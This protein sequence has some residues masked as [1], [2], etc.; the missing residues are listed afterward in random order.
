MY[1]KNNNLLGLFNQDELQQQFQ[2]QLLQ[3]QLQLQK[4]E[5]EAQLQQQQISE[6]EK[7]IHEIYELI[8]EGNARINEPVEKAALILGKTGAGK[9]TLT[10]LLAKKQLT[11]KLDDATGN[12]LV[13]AI[14]QLD[15]ITISHKSASETKIP[16]RHK[17]ENISLWDCPGFNDTGGVA[18]EIANAF[19]IKKLFETT[20]QLKFIL[21]ISD[22]SM[23]NRSVDVV[24]IVEHFV[25]LFKDVTVL[26]KSVSLV[27]TQALP[28][29]KTEH[30]K[31]AIENIISENKAIEPDTKAVLGFLLNSVHIFYQPVKEGLINQENSIL[32]AINDSTEYIN[33]S[34]NL[35]NIAISK[36]SSEFAEELFEITKSNFT[37]L[38]NTIADAVKNQANKFLNASS[39]SNRNFF[40]ESLEKIKYY[41]GIG[42]SFSN[43][44]FLKTNKQKYF[45]DLDQICSFQECFDKLLSSI[46][47]NQDSDFDT[48]KNNIVNILKIFKRYN[49]QEE[50]NKYSSA[51]IQQTEYVKFLKSVCEKKIIDLSSFYQTFYSCKLL[52]DQ[53]SARGVQSMSLDKNNNDVAYYKKAIQYL[54]KYN[55]SECNKIKAEA[56][57][58]IGKLYDLDGNFKEAI[59]NYL[60]AAGLDKSQLV[61]YKRVGDILLDKKLYQEAIKCFKVVSDY[62]KVLNCFK[63]LIKLNEDDPNL[64]LQ[65]GDYLVSIGRDEKAIG[66][67]QDAFSLSH[68]DDFKKKMVDK[69]WPLVNSKNGNY[70]SILL[71]QQA[72]NNFCNQPEIKSQDLYDSIEQYFED[73][74]CVGEADILKI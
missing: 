5:L 61:V 28:H 67:Y 11:A 72:Y 64:R 3:Q 69:I 10:H 33:T 30:I 50:L 63:E 56:F 55:T 43:Q 32:E 70:T 26:Q 60:N 20:K 74:S 41:S 1:K 7:I 71:N 44:I 68:D 23:S 27:I 4:L 35:A 17:L 14:D 37:Q 19:Y 24:T 18:Q 40:A 48:F 16:N 46:S 12:M 65:K 59:S 51:F 58:H 31:K 25:K 6:K 42:S 52:I 39:Y 36:K 66:C 21:V 8:G 22:S 57:Y 2:L 13:E 62:I 73:T 38:I 54:Q 45:L 15:G 9:S 29:K 53:A 34:L 47:K 49:E